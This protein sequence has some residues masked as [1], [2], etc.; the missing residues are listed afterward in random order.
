MSR[1]L[2][3]VLLAGLLHGG[4]Q[5]AE[6]YV[7]D[8]L[9]E[10]QPW[11]LDGK[12][13]RDCPFLF[14]AGAKDRGDFLCAW[15]GPLDVA[16]VGDGARFMLQWTVHADAQWLP[17]PGDTNYWPHRVE[18]NDR[19]AEVVLHDGVPGLY[20]G[21]GSYRVAGRF[22]WDEKPGVLRVP[23]N[24][25]LVALVVDG[26]RVERPERT[27]NG[28]FLGVR[29][30][31]SRERD[32]VTA[33]VY[34]LVEDNVPSRLSTQLQIDVAGGVREELFG[35]LLPEGFTPL[36]I[37]SA[38]PARLEPDG[39][40]RV[41]ARPGRWIVTLDAR[42]AGVIDAL[43]LR[44]PEV[45]LPDS[46]IWSYR[47]NDLFRVTMAAAPSPVDPAQVQVPAR[48][49]QLPAFRMR[50]GATLTLTERSRGIVSADNELDLTRTL[51]LDF[52]GRGYTASDE[53]D[54]TMRTG[55]RLD[56]R[57][58][59]A[60]LMAKVDGDNLLITQGAGEGRAGVEL[61]SR[62]LAL[63]TLAR[64]E[65]RGR[66][67]VTGWDARFASVSAE[68]QLPPGN[69]LFAAPGADQAPGS[70]VGRWKLLDFFVVLIVTIGT[71]RLLGRGAG[72]IALLALV[73][74]YHEFAAPS[75]L[76]LNL[77]V[78]SALLRV[79]PAG[80][81]QQA[82]RSYLA[83]SAL[84]LVLVL[85]PFIAGQL[86][87]AIYPQLEPLGGPVSAMF[88]APPPPAT[89]PAGIVPERRLESGPA[90]YDMAAS[91][92]S[93]SLEEVVVTGN[94]VQSDFA[95]YA[96]NAVVQAGPGVPSWEW[97]R[98]EL[99]WDGPVDA[100]Q[101]LRLVILPRWAVTLLRF[102]EVLALL[103]LAAVFAR[104]ISGRSFALPPGLRTGNAAA[105]VLA[106]AGVVTILAG[107]MPVARAE[108]PDKA[109]LDELEQRL[110]RPPEC[111]PHCA[112]LAAASVQ[113][114]RDSVTMRLTV[115][116]LAEVAVPL[117]GSEK[118]WH[119]NA[120]RLDGTA[121]GEVFRRPDATL[122]VRLAPG[123]HTIELGGAVPDVDSLEIPFPTPPRV[124]EAAADGWQVAGIKDRRLLAGS[125]QL[126]RLDS[127]A[128]AAGAPRWE[129]SRFP[130]FVRV[131]RSIDLDLDWRATTTV[132]RV[133]PVQGALTLELPL[134]DG[135]TVVSEGMTVNDGRI[136][137]SM[138]PNQN[139]VSWRSNL[140][141][142]S[143]MMVSA[144]SGAAWQEIWRVGVGAVW[145]AGFSG[146]PES[147]NPQVASGARVALFYPRG[148]EQLTI[149]A[150]RPEASEGSTLA[151]DSVALASEIGDRSSNVTL[152]LA[153][154]S[155]RG[156]QHVIRLPADAEVTDVE[157]DGESQSL[158]AGGGELT[159]PILPG[160]HDV[161]VAWRAAGDVGFATRTP[162]V[163]IGA[164]S[165]NVTLDTQ[166]PRNRW[167]LAT[168][169]PRLG[170]AVLYWSELVVLILFAVILGRTT[171]APLTT[172]HWLLLGLGFSTFNW[173]VLGVVVAWLLICG[174]KE[175]FKPESQWW[176]YNLGQFIVAAATIAALLLILFSLPVGLLGTPDMHVAGN[177]SYGNTLNWFADSS[178]GVLPTAV[179]WTVPMWVYKVLILAWALWLSFALIRWLPWVWRCFTSGG[180]WRGRPKQA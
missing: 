152:E 106:A 14:S 34:R 12:E 133:A 28:V 3:V 64:S 176:R 59:F 114:D 37:D 98:Y 27:A 93:S 78:A 49:Q 8:A 170:P 156:A 53:I 122:W 163:D 159:L 23:D 17:L 134:L 99:D 147:E 61:R 104:E 75:W 60:L 92:A 145:H 153:Y 138:S 66:M 144:E 26:R 69:M 72:L 100:D 31:E 54:G 6:T 178:D 174:A 137:V 44:A 52:D 89:A 35:P 80:R 110:T 84:A 4:A 40:L 107:A 136:L 41:Q 102:V 73:L 168:Q 67:P 45:N 9:K 149:D 180:Y 87:I 10:W 79:A 25:G 175:R 169:G 5:G 32:A 139:A 1:F 57:R 70:W 164:P 96:P 177:D 85:V 22:D 19:A 42:A 13:Y 141:R 29:R 7:P 18:V 50:P 111:A 39:K 127:G 123:Q 108:M 63:E 20:L 46:E 94:R 167:L 119:P 154:R 68:L 126:S 103:A 109:L 95:R 74:S 155:T 131:E 101:T 140:P 47:A 132:A 166:L 162:P 146:V 125:L 81:L 171:L 90:M 128:G 179:A 24:I 88:E 165:G 83:L 142:H 112:E 56:M 120:V 76:W 62:D 105:S 33:T 86:R 43:S 157:I 121:S 160:E 15:P 113:V 124:I 158:R 135:E 48:W 55:W 150:T 118:G 30:E 173:P 36:A 117:P 77:L 21:P 129:S 148:G 130:A 16:V 82:V 115:H 65:T 161:H 151:F 38:L 97:N 71:W 51:W 58:P 11:V 143:P 91:K 172:R 116:A 2:K